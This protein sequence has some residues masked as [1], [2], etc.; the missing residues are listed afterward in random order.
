ME[1]PTTEVSMPRPR[2]KMAPLRAGVS[3]CP[4]KSGATV[5]KE[6]NLANPTVLGV[7]STTR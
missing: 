1:A 7:A 2:P 4:N 5:H 3:H 6:L